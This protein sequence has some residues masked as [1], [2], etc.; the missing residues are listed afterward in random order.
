MIIWMLISDVA[1][2]LP[3]FFLILS[4]YL[5]QGGPKSRVKCLIPR[6][7]LAW[8]ITLYFSLSP[9]SSPATVAM[10]GSESG[11]GLM[12]VQMILIPSSPDG[13]A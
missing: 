5:E 8:D 7:V 3:F 6:D 11:A 2:K 10:K 13:L 9:H 1:T 4:L 12:D